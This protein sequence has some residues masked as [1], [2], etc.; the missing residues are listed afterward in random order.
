[1]KTSADSDRDTRE[2]QGRPVGG[3]NSKEQN[4][5]KLTCLGKE[6][7]VGV[8]AAVP[9]VGGHSCRP[10]A[11]GFPY[12]YIKTRQ[13]KHCSGQGENIALFYHRN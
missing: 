13:R 10:P 5:P 2:F 7:V 11:T 12:D 3:T 6:V 8:L 9:P 1:M 4:F